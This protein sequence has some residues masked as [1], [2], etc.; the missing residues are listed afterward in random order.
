[1]SLNDLPDICLWKIFENIDEAKDLI[2]LSKVCSRWSDLIKPR[3]N[4]V[5]YLHLMDDAVDYIDANSLWINPKTNWNYYNLFKL[6]PNI[7]IIDSSAFDYHSSFDL[8]EI[9]KIIHK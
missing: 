7:K 3:F 6:F 8:P 1:M 2:R 5:K 4:R 9:V